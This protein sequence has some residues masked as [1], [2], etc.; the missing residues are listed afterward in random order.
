VIVISAS[1]KISEEGR[2]E[3]RTTRKLVKEL[4]KNLVAWT[5]RLKQE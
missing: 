4:L 3:D 5:Q 2:V 1:D